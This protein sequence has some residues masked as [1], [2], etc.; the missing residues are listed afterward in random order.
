M[1]FG[2]VTLVPYIRELL[3]HDVLSLDEAVKLER[4]VGEEV[5]SKIWTLDRETEQAALRVPFP[6]TE[7]GG[8]SPQGKKYLREQRELEK[9]GKL[10]QPANILA[11]VVAK[12]TEIA[13]VI[14]SIAKILIDR[15]REKMQSTCSG[16]AT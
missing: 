14:R 2:P 15:C 6:L 16:E 11:S 12:Q 7:A 10:L 9:E 1:T 8:K 4:R 3:E 5:D 13:E